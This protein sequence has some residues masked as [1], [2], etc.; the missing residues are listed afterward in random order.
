MS[1]S[2]VEDQLNDFRC[3]LNEIVINE[4]NLIKNLEECLEQLDQ[5]INKFKENQFNENLLQRL[6]QF[7]SSFKFN[8]ENLQQTIEFL[9]NDFKQFLQDF[10]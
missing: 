6:D 7:I 5:L 10:H 4:R 3:R 8:E 2:S 1:N 9:K